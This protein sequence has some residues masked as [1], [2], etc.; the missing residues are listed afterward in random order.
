MLAEENVACRMIEEVGSF[1]A[2]RDRVLD[3]GEVQLHTVEQWPEVATRIVA[4]RPSPSAYSGPGTGFTM[5]GTNV[6]LRT[7]IRP[8]YPDDQKRW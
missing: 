5:V 7:I 4:L 6:N 8:S 3:L 2:V 1:Q